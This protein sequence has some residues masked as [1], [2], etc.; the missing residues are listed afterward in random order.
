V[1]VG[2]GAQLLGIR[3]RGIEKEDALFEAL[4]LNQHPDGS[5]KL[6]PRNM[7]NSIRFYD[8]QCS[9]QKSVSIMAITLGDRRLYEAHDRATR[10]ALAELEKFA[11][12]QAGQGRHKHRQTTGNLCAAA[13]RH[14]ASRELDPQ[15][16]THFVVANA[17]RDPTTKRWLALE[18]HDMFKAIR[19]AGKVYQ[20]ELARECRRLGYEIEHIRNEKGAIEGFEIKGVSAEIRQRFSKRRAEVEAAIA[21]FV[22]ERG[23]QPTAAEI[24]GLTRETRAFK[25]KEVTTP[26]VLARQ[27]AQLSLEELRTLERVRNL[28]LSR[29]LAE[30]VLL[31]PEKALAA[32][33]QH[34]FE[35]RSVLAGHEILAEALN[36]GLGV[37]DRQRLTASLD[38]SESGLLPVGTEPKEPLNQPYATPEGLA[39]ERWAVGFVNGTKEAYRPLGPTEGISFQFQSDEQRRVVLETL[40]CPDQVCAIRGVAGAGKTTS[41]REIA[42]SLEGSGQQV[43]YLAPTG[44]AAKV[45]KGDGF[46]TATTVSD[47]LTNR[48]KN[49]AERLR[50]AVLIVDEAG[51][52]SNKLGAAVLKVAEKTGARVLFVGDTR[53][54]VSVEAGDFLRILEAHS[55]MQVAELRTVRRQLVQEYNHAIREMAAGQTAAGMER[56]HALG[57]VQEARKGYLDTAADAYLRETEGGKQLDRTIAVSPTWAENYR[58]TEAIRSR[59]KASGALLEG[60]ETVVHDS[61]KWTRQ[62]MRKAANYRPGLVVTFNLGAS[63]IDRGQSLV[64]ERVEGSRIY[65]EG[66]DKPFEPHWH[67]GKIDVAEQ[68]RVEVSIGDRLLI[69]RNDR[70]AGLVNGDVVTVTGIDPDGAIHT[71]EGAILG[72]GFRDF[73]HGYVVTSHKAQGRTHTSVI[74]AAEEADAKAAYVACSRGRERCSVFTPDLVHF[75]QRLG[76]SGDRTAALD[77][78]PLVAAGQLPIHPEAHPNSSRLRNLWESI[79]ENGMTFAHRLQESVRRSLHD[80]PSLVPKLNCSGATPE[81]TFEH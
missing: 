12:I 54:H 73:C 70:K 62:Q 32:A 10:I 43:Y 77:L 11:A 52:Q 25:L 19:Y 27:R 30:P 40:T 69:R 72:A 48:I 3:D 21:E 59:L 41:L 28:A 75:M 26:D 8:F 16:H 60:R 68:R 31:A 50:N 56:L 22:A 63:G 66:R 51:L 81:A 58:L 79:K 61:L 67:A 53:Q 34:L 7:D 14:D 49:E 13:F 20:N 37:L 24:A 47:F 74:L 9:A 65:F 15:L 35:R 23:R 38:A 33:R 18:T 55:R 39:L 5:G 36:Q 57:W 2:K 44:S 29:S 1:W 45:L 17:T 6:T 78:M 80:D 42:R 4:R 71:R 76:R 46:G 64:V